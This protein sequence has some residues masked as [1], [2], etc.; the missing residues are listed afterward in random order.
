MNKEKVKRLVEDLS[1]LTM[2]EAMT[3]IGNLYTKQGITV[4]AATVLMLQAAVDD[5]EGALGYIQGKL[6]LVSI[7]KNAK[8]S[9]IKALRVH[10]NVGLKDA[11]ELADAVPVMLEDKELHLEPQAKRVAARELSR[12]G[13]TVEFR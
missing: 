7:G 5:P 3:V 11:K 12:A 6:W 13:G 9:V 2:P 1:T 8:I 10:Y 4:T